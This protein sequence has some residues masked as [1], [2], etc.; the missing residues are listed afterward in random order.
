[1]SVDRSV[2]YQMYAKLAE[3]LQLLASEVPGLGTPRPACCTRNLNG[4]TGQRV[5][6]RGAGIA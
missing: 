1:V 4:R 6:K 3:E 2:F 5:P